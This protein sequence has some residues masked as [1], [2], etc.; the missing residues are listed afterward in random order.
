[1]SNSFLFGNLAGTTLAAPIS[2][3]ATT[4][5]VA[6]GTGALF[7]Q[8]TA[9]QQFALRLISASNSTYTEIVYVTAISG[10]V[11][12]VARA[13]ESTAPLSFNAGDYA[14]HVL[15]AG[16]LNSFPTKSNV[17]IFPPQTTFYVN[18]ASG[19][20]TTGNGLTAGTA[21]ATMQNAVNVISNTYV[22]PGTITINVANGTY[23][24]PAGAYACSI[25]MSQIAAWNIVGNSASPTSVVINSTAA[26][27]RGFS[28][29]NGAVVQV[30]GFTTSAYYEAYVAAQHGTLNV[31]N[32]NYAGGPSGYSGSGSA[33]PFGFASYSGS[34]LTCY[35]LTRGTA[36]LIGVSGPCNS[37]FT[38][39]SGGY[40]NAGYTDINGTLPVSFTFTSATAYAAFL[41]ITSSASATFNT[42]MITTSGTL[43]GN[44]FGLS[45]NGIIYVYG[46]STS[47]LPGTVTPTSP[48]STGGQYA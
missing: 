8:P 25:G 1:M 6:A 16:A 35:A 40:L 44:K 5:S 17:L 48:Y 20:D 42:T 10:D 30:T 2:S 27:S 9:G 21:W 46:A 11:L 39:N 32:C 22:Y 47:A 3:T 15:T 19:S 31:T 24:T 36:N 37:V 4:I 29:G 38:A 33:I 7:P 12:T 43:T 23:V 13:Q 41:S 26:G 18:F 28:S 34:T 14:K 45:L